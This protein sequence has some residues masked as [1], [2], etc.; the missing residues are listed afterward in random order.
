MIS[1]LKYRPMPNPEMVFGIFIFNPVKTVGQFFDV[2]C[3][4]TCSVIFNGNIYLIPA[5]LPN[6][7]ISVP[8]GEYFTAL[9]TR[10]AITDAI[11]GR[12][13]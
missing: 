2:L 10:F 8:F 12:S 1:L 6:I 5:S 4:N 7:S 13:A 3:L 11:L 9:L